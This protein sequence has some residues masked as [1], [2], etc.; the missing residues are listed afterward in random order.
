MVGDCPVHALGQIGRNDV[1]A[2]H[3]M[4][5]QRETIREKNRVIGELVLESYRKSREIERLRRA[6]RR[7]EGAM[8]HVVGTARGRE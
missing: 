1:E 7:L 5:L 3:V 6:V 8:D 2:R 4:A